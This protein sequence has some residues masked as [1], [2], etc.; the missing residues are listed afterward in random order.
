MREE[1]GIK[2]IIEAVEKLAKKHK[3]HIAVYGEGN[4]ERLTGLHET[5][6]IED[7]S[8]GVGNRGASI[9]IPTSVDR[10]GKGYFE[11]RRPASN[12]D[13]YKVT[14]KI[15]ETTILWDGSDE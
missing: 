1:G 14:Q 9:R 2:V 6:S 8:Y 4:D 10:E 3:E 15:V 7:F 12:I 11:D 13:P 5:S